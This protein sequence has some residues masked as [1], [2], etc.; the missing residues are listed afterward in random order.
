L[1]NEDAI[2]LFAKMRKNRN[3]QTIIDIDPFGTPNVFIDSAIQATRNH[4]MLAITATDTMVLFG[5]KSDACFRKYNTKSLRSTFLKEIG[6]RILL[7]FTAI[8]AHPHGKHIKPLLSLSFDHYIRVFVQINRGKEGVKEN[9]KNLG[10]VLWCPTCDWRQTIDLDITK[11]HE[12]CPLCHGKLVFGGP[13]WIG[14]LHD[15]EFV[16]ECNKALDQSEL[17][18]IPSKKRLQK[19]LLTVE[20]EDKFPVGF[21]DLHKICDKLGISVKKTSIILDN[22]REA[23]FQAGLTHI[24][25]RAI[26]S[27]IPIEKLKQILLLLET[28]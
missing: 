13:L 1:T 9:H 22:I 17:T 6:L 14:N 15:K 18:E 12:S 10:Y 21:Y 11:S 5:V 28:H 7:Y 25:H 3:F 20:N 4:G 2:F 24:E 8:R 16:Q 23:G 26:K 27:N 19:V